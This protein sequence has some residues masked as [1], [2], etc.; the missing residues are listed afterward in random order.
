MN[1]AGEVELNRLRD[2]SQAGSELALNIKGKLNENSTYEVGAEAM[3]PFV[4]NKPSGDDR[5]AIR[6]TNVDAFAKLSSNLTSWATFG[7]DYKLK[8]QP[9]LV[10][11]AQQIHMF[12]INLNHNLF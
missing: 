2:V 5:D 6:L 7:Y 3:T 10:D 8:I 12:V 9:Q 4:N 1:S 11:R